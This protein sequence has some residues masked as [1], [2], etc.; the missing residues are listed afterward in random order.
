MNYCFCEGCNFPQH[1]LTSY[2]KC[3]ACGKFGHGLRECEKSNEGSYD[4]QNRLFEKYTLNNNLKLSP[5]LHCKVDDCLCKDTHSTGSHHNLFSKDKFGGIHGP[6]QYGITAIRHKG[7]DDG[8]R[9]VELRTNTF[10]KHWWGMGQWI[11][12]R[13]LNGKISTNTFECTDD[14]GIYNFTKNL[15]EIKQ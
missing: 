10:Y 7:E 13:N 3:G 6:D 15:T 9:L 1:H 2:H 8:R 4:K 5:S 12:T 14:K 11:I